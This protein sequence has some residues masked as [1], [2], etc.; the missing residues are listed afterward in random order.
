MLTAI[1]TTER[2][3]LAG[4][5]G[6]EEHVS[7]T[8]APVNQPPKRAAVEDEEDGQIPGQALRPRAKRTKRGSS[9]T[10]R[11]SAGQPQQRIVLKTKMDQTPDT[12]SPA[13]PGAA[14]AIFNQFDAGS[15]GA[16]LG[17]GNR[18]N[19]PL[20]Q[21]Q[22]ALEQ[23]RKQRVDYALAQHRSE[24]MKISQ[25]KR[26]SEA[27]FVRAERLLRGL[28]D[29]Y[30][31]DDENSWGKGGI[32]PNPETEDDYGETASFFLST[33]RKTARRLQRWDWD[34]TAAGETHSWVNEIGRG[35]K[36]E[37]WPGVEEPEAAPQAPPPTT[38]PKGRGGRRKK[39]VSTA[40]E[41]GKPA[42]GK[43]GGRAGGRKRGTGE[44][45]KSRAS[46]KAPKASAA[47]TAVKQEA[48]THDHSPVPESRPHSSPTAQRDAEEHTAHENEAQDDL[49]KELPGEFDGGE[50]NQPELPDP[51]PKSSPKPE[52]AASSPAFLQPPVDRIGGEEEGEDDGS[53]VHHDNAPP[54]EEPGNATDSDAETDEEMASSV[55]G[56]NGYPGDES[57]SME[58]DNADAAEGRADDSMVE[59]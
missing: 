22:L 3:S 58:I 10:N 32:C 7:I 18:K 16:N 43:R 52:E 15:P 21:H 25:S 38:K 48:E 37:A 31:S 23:N 57:F 11:T 55:A 40:G 20:T 59:T 35:H 12:A 29:G 14:H 26:Q 51:S 54:A 39:A 33:L 8:W 53:S 44:G 47:K 45:R 1:S 4:R 13:P 24:S 50:E 34:A 6:S 17:S 19:R 28:P 9:T 27:P 49:D 41:G 46:G 5:R 56:A 42:T 30:D 2:A 36:V